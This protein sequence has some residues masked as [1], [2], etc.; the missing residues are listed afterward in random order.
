ME[1]KKQELAKIDP[2]DFKAQMELGNQ[3]TQMQQEAHK[4]KRALKAQ[5]KGRGGGQQQAPERAPAKAA[6]KYVAP[7]AKK[8]EFQLMMEKRD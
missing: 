6:T 5:K 1:E 7:Q 2:F 4:E 3:L 8:S